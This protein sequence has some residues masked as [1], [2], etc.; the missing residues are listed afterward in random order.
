MTL[1]M[2]SLDDTKLRPPRTGFQVKCILCGTE[3][4]A[5][6]FYVGKNSTHCGPCWSEIIKAEPNFNLDVVDKVIDAKIT[7]KRVAEE[8]AQLRK[9]T[10]QIPETI[11]VASLSD[12]FRKTP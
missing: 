1:T 8:T 11:Q 4:P 12:H 3:S 9:I 2:Q 6:V 5:V 10:D 7:Q